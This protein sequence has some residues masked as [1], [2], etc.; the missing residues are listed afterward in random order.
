MKAESAAIHHHDVVIIGGGLT[1]LRAALRIADAD[2]NA[3]V[4][5]KVHPLRSHSVAAQGGMNASLG[6]V[7][8]ADGTVDSWKAH[9]YDTVKGSDYLA[10]QDA[11]E[12]MCRAAP[13]AVI[14]LEHMG[15]VWSRLPN[16]KIAQRP[17]GGA[18]FPR[19]CYAADRTGHNALH[20]LYEQV[21]DR[22]IPVYDEFFVMSLVTT[23]GRCAGCTAFELMTGQVHGFFAK[24]VLL[25]TGGFGR[26][27]KKSTNAL[28][29]TGDGQALA[30]RAG[31]RLKD[32]EFVQFHPTT[33]YGSNI[34]ITEA[35]RGEGGMLLNRNGERFMKRYAPQLVDLAPRDVVARATE[36][37]IAEGR[38]YDGGYVHL[39][40]RHLGA[41]RINERL[42]GIRQI[43]VDFAGVDPVRDP[44]P[45]Q[46]GQHYSMG[47]VDV[48]CN[49][50]S[51]L[52]GLYAAGECACVSVHGA[53]RLGGNSLLE[54]V[55][56]GRLVAE[57][58]IRDAPKI[59]PCDD[60]PVRAAVLSASSKI[61]GILRRDGGER[62]SELRDRLTRTMSKAFGL[63]RSDREMSEGLAEIGR[64]QDRVSHISLQ[65]KE[66]ALNQAL[67]RLLE[68]K[69]ML[70][71]GEAVARGALAR[72]ESRGSH[73]RV[74]HPGRDDRTFL[75]HTLVG[76]EGD[77]MRVSYAPVR[78]GLF[79]PEERVY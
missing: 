39:D 21:T 22:R 43:A 29:N 27:F 2:L 13:T 11:V 48:D 65:N 9:A 28:I 40:L 45:V 47:G 68:L 7:E 75:K 52:P 20:T 24:A 70:S 67:I 73:M 32:M 59:P 5:S 6:N 12:R 16:G 49:G 79:E 31:A 51:S 78:L 34:L 15:M 60:G 56:F 36:Q 42:P 3:A 77:T 4:V 63:F 19:T 50:A 61:D 46:P 10:D 44:V 35:A 38:G 26:I 69:N 58:I 1:G 57:Q 62:F 66:R 37:E 74:D 53:N 8:T 23:S 30:L 55:V 33:L 41:D 17:F 18:G 64:V 72:K 71:L 14:E 25:A 76:C 54:T